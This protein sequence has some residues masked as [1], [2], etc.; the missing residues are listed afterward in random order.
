MVEYLTLDCYFD[1]E[2]NIYK[3]I[4]VG[5]GKH[6]RE[7]IKNLQARLQPVDLTSIN[8]RSQEDVV[9]SYIQKFLIECH[10]NPKDFS[11]AKSIVY[12]F[13]QEANLLR[14]QF[15][16]TGEIPTLT[17]GEYLQLHPLA[18]STDLENLKQGFS[19]VDYKKAKDIEWESWNS[20][21][22]SHTARQKSEL[23]Y[24]YA[25]KHLKLD[26]DYAAQSV[27]TEKITEYEIRV[28]KNAMARE[29]LVNVSA[30]DTER[31]RQDLN[32]AKF[33]KLHADFS[34]EKKSN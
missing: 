1:A 34:K 2:Y 3:N 19:V 11:W 32:Q 27:L 30:V 33:E 20:G 5:S 13:N 6:S 12:F 14:L 7:Q 4:F 21:W 10:A 22:C 23:Q 16:L 9:N 25:K 28:L 8:N 17:L 15:T 29:I 26:E 31:R 18:L 24:S